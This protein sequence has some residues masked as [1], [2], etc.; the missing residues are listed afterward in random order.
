MGVPAAGAEG[1]DAPRNLSRMLDG[2]LSKSPARATSE[3][4]QHIGDVRGAS[5]NVVDVM[6]Q[7]SKIITYLN[8]FI[9]EVATA[10]DG[11]NA[12]TSEIA[13][14]VEQ[15]SAGIQDITSNIHGV[16]DS[17]VETDTLAARTETDSG[18]L[19]EQAMRLADEVKTFLARAAAQV[20]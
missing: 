5:Q 15:A 3:I 12:A 17:A 14:N 20:A 11:Q 18:T 10:V 8:G 16:S 7:I 6:G 19:S 2:A 4:T 1:W 13:R 9:T